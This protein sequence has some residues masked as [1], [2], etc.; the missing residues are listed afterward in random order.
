[1]RMAN[2]RKLQRAED[3]TF[4]LWKVNLNNHRVFRDQRCWRLIALYH[5]V[6]MPYVNFEMHYD[7][8][9]SDANSKAVVYTLYSMS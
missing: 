6:P 2:E 5:L 1:M 7:F 8:Y 4:L 3:A 9:G